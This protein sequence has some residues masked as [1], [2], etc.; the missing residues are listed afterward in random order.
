MRLVLVFVLDLED[1][2]EVGGCCVDLDEVFVWFGD[3][4]RDFSDFEFC[5][6][7]GVDFVNKRMN[8]KD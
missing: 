5:W 7:L 6:V 8:Y 1:V 2:E 4:V 3:W